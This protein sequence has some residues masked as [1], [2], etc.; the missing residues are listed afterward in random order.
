MGVTQEA[1]MTMIAKAAFNARNAGKHAWLEY[2]PGGQGKVNGTT[3]QRQ[4]IIHTER[5][6]LWSPLD[7]HKNP[8][9]IPSAELRRDIVKMN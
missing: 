9:R 1:L 3:R 6:P 5:R 2:W 8:D 7:V 4:Y